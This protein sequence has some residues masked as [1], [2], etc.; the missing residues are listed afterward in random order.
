LQVGDRGLG[1]KHAVVLEEEIGAFGTGLNGRAVRDADAEYEDRFQDDPGHVSRGELRFNAAL[2]AMGGRNPAER[3]RR[4]RQVER[5]PNLRAQWTAIP[6]PE[7]RPASKVAV[8]IVASAPAPAAP[9]HL[10]FTD[11]EAR[12]DL[13]S[14]FSSLSSQAKT[15]AKKHAEQVLGE[16]SGS[17]DSTAT[18]SRKSTRQSLGSSTH[19]EKIAD[20]KVSALM[21]LV[22]KAAASKSFQEALVDAS[23]NTYRGS[24]V[25]DFE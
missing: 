25:G 19:G 20:Q 22:K 15:Q 21:K 6:E 16:L 24:V 11:S 18:T 10:G 1:S 12:T 8:N 5:R 2:H 13:N 7:E 9:T 4:Y 3:R 14:Y 23:R 17:S